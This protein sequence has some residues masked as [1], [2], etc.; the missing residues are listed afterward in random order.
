MNPIDDLP[1]D[2]AELID[3][4][5]AEAARL[6]DRVSD[7]VHNIQSKAD[8]EIALIRR[9]GEQ[10]IQLKAIALI[11]QIKPLQC[12]Q[13][14]AGKLDEAL[15][16]R[17]AIRQIRGMVINALP[18]P[19]NLLGYQDKVGQEYVFE[20]VGA[21][22]G[23]LWGSDPYTLDSMLACAAVHAGVLAAGHKGNVRAAIQDTS[24]MS[25]FEGTQRNG[26]TSYPWGP[27]PAGY[28]LSKA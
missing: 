28:R 25:H 11:D 9:K 16:I 17:D 8:E 4:F 26:V 12:E 23:P 14:K 6:R 27:Y 19:G 18:D 10:K 13:L 24:D 22:Q 7:E 5:E 15:A 20:V 1:A 21:A 2:V 3:R